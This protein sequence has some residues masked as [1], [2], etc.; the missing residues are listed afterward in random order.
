MFDTYADL[1]INVASITFEEAHTCQRL[2]FLLQF[3][4]SPALFV[5]LMAVALVEKRQEA[6]NRIAKEN[7]QWAL[8]FDEFN[9]LAWR[10]RKMNELLYR[11]ISATP[12]PTWVLYLSKNDAALINAYN[13]FSV[14]LKKLIQI[15]FRRLSEVID[16]DSKW[17]WQYF[18][19]FWKD[20]CTS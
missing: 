15:H 6:E 7:K 5:S 1:E 19:N 2:D 13:R 10:N 12:S 11:K 3:W 17:H 9:A 18:L 14:I 16:R 20:M 8:H 4:V